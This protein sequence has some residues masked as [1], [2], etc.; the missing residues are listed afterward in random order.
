MNSTQRKFCLGSGTLL[1]VVAVG[2]GL[3]EWQK[4]QPPSRATHST[5]PTPIREHSDA[6]SGEVP[7][8]T[9]D[10]KQLAAA[11]N[12]LQQFADYQK[13]ISKEEPPRVGIPVP[14]KPGMVY[15]PYYDKGYVDVVGLPSGSQVRCP[16][17]KK[18]FLVP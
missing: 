13:S 16:Y 3:F 11:K 6:A 7:S 15:S 2:Y 9:D 4:K 14:G 12:S 17:T 10:A 18:M 1:V 5:G 8:D